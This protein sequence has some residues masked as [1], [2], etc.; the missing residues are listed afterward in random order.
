MSFYFY[1]HLNSL[2]RACNT[3]L[4]TRDKNRHPCLAP[5]PTGKTFSFPW[6]NMILAVHYSCCQVAS[7]VSDSLRPHRQQPTRLLG[8]SRIPGILQ[9]R[10]LA[11]VAISFSNAWKWKV[12]GKSPSRARLLATPW[13]AAHQAPPSMGLSRQEYQSGVPLLSLPFACTASFSSS[14]QFGSLMWWASFIQ[15]DQDVLFLISWQDDFLGA[16]FMEN[17]NT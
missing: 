5:D 14:Q 12:K 11:W 10:I 1:S 17:N 8:F 13:T 6:L 2:A 7:V 3:L 4:N 9:A 15:L 16:S